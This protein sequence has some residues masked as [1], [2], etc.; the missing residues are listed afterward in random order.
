M[1]GRF[2]LCD[3]LLGAEEFDVRPTQVVDELLD[4]VDRG[5]PRLALLAV[6]RREALVVRADRRVRLLFRDA[7]ELHGIVELSALVIL[8]GVHEDARRLLR[9][10][11][12]GRR[13]LAAGLCPPQPVAG[14]ARELLL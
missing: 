3:R 6:C 5:A 8:A 4:P 12:K 9:L 11:A 2:G 13:L 14:G 10:E 1:E 7:R